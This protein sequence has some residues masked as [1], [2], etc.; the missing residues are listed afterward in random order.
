M[1]TSLAYGELLAFEGLQNSVDHLYR[2]YLDAALVQ[3]KREAA[4]DA[5]TYKNRV[6]EFR[7]IELE[8]DTSL[9]AFLYWYDVRAIFWA[10]EESAGFALDDFPYA[11]ELGLLHTQARALKARLDR[12]ARVQE[13]SADRSPQTAAPATNF[14]KPSRQVGAAARSTALVDRVLNVHAATMRNLDEQQS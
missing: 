3:L 2:A 8:S 7:R 13:L 5:T 4:S 6:R 10:S 1:S 12:L 14:Y 9:R 11:V